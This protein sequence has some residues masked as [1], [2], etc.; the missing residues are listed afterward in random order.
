MAKARDKHTPTDWSF[1]DAFRYLTRNVGLQDLLALYQLEENILAGR[2]PARCD[3]NVI[4]PS[5]WRDNLGLELVEG[6]AE[7]VA[8]RAF[9]K[10]IHAYR[11][12][13]TDKDVG[14]LW[15]PA[16]P[17]PVPTRQRSRKSTTQPFRAETQNT[18][19]INI[20]RKLALKPGML[21]REVRKA[22]NGPYK[23]EHHDTPSDT[24]VTRAYHKY[25]RDG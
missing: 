1:D 3:G 17:S 13:V 6:R 16:N 4:R 12:T 5:F 19:L 10:L 7:V 2:L 24:A 9:E 20:M 18:R 22:V 8:R 23:H 25:E 11:F 15:R 21:P 14:G